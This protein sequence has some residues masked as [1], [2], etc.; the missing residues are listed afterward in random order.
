MKKTV[1][2][3]LMVLCMVCLS[4]LFAAV[5]VAAATDYGL[6]I[7]GKAVT[8][9]YK[10][11]ASEGW[12]F[13]PAANTLTLTDG[14]KFTA[15]FEKMTQAKDMKIAT[16]SRYDPSIGSAAFA[17]YMAA[18]EVKTLTNLTVKVTGDVT[19]GR[20][21]WSDWSNVG[22]TSERSPIRSLGFYS[23]SGGIT[24][25]GDGKLTVY[26]SD[27]AFY[28]NGDFK[29]DGKVRLDLETYRT[30]A[31]YAQGKIIIDNGS[32]V[33][34]KTNY[35]CGIYKSYYSI[36]Y[37]DGSKGEKDSEGTIQYDSMAAVISTKGT[38]PNGISVLNGSTL[39][40]DAHLGD[41]EE[42]KIKL[43]QNREQMPDAS[44]MSD[45]TR[46][47]YAIWA[48]RA[49]INIEGKSKLK[50]DIDA[51]GDLYRRLHPAVIGWKCLY[52]TI[53]VNASNVTVKNSDLVIEAD[54]RD[55][56]FE[57]NGI[58]YTGKELGDY[59]E[60][61]YDQSFYYPETS[62]KDN[63]I[64]AS[65]FY[66]RGASSVQLSMDGTYGESNLCRLLDYKSDR[67]EFSSTY[68]GKSY[69]YCEYPRGDYNGGVYLYL[70]SYEKG[71]T[72]YLRKNGDKYEY[73]E[74]F[75]FRSGIKYIN[76]N[77]LDIAAL[78]WSNKTIYIRSGN[79]TIK[80]PVN[81]NAKIIHDN[82]ESTVTIKLEGGKTYNGI[83][84]VTIA[85]KLI[86]EGDGIIKELHTHGTSTLMWDGHPGLYE[87]AVPHIFVNSGTIAGGSSN[88]VRINV[89]GG[90][91]AYN[92]D[93]QADYYGPN[94]SRTLKRITIDLGEF[95]DIFTSD[96]LRISS[97][98]SH[99]TTGLYPVDG[100][101]YFWELEDK[102]WNVGDHPSQLEFNHLEITEDYTYY[103]YPKKVTDSQG[104]VINRQY[105]LYRLPERL[106]IY[107][108]NKTEYFESGTN[109]YASGV[110]FGSF[111]YSLLV[112]RPKYSDPLYTAETTT[113]E[114]CR[115]NIP[116]NGD[117]VEWTCK[118]KDGNKITLGR[119]Y[120]SLSLTTG[121]LHYR[122]YDYKCTLY[123]IDGKVK[124]SYDFD[125]YILLFYNTGDQYAAKGQ[126]VTFEAQYY[127][128]GMWLEDLGFQWAWQ[129]RTGS[130]ATWNIVYDTDAFFDYTAFDESFENNSHCYQFR[131][132]AYLSRINEELVLIGSPI[133]LLN[134]STHV[135]SAPET[136]NIQSN[137]PAETIQIT[138][139]AERA[140]II[141]WWYQKEGWSDE[142]QISGANSLTLSLPRS[143]YTDENG[144]WDPSKVD[145]TYYCYI[146]NMRF[147][148][149]T[150]VEIDVKVVDH[151][152]FT[153][154]PKDKVAA[155]G[156]IAEFNVGISKDPPFCGELW[157]EYSF[158]DGATWEKVTQ[159]TSNESFIVQPSVYFIPIETDRGIVFHSHYDAC[160]LTVNAAGLNAEKILVRCGMKDSVVTY[161]TKTATLT[162]VDMPVI[163]TQPQSQVVSVTQGTA[164]MEYAF[165]AP[166]P[167]EYTVT[168]QWQG[169]NDE[170]ELYEHWE[171][172]NSNDTYTCSD[173]RIEFNLSKHLF[174]RKYRCKI[175]FTDA[176]GVTIDVYTAEATLE[177]VTMPVIRSITWSSSYITEG[178]HLA[179]Y[180]ARDP[181]AYQSTRYT[182]YKWQICK[183]G[184]N[185]VEPDDSFTMSTIGNDKFCIEFDTTKEMDGW[186]VRFL[187]IN[188]YGGITNTAISGA[189][190]LNVLSDECA[191]EYELRQ[192]VVY[193]RRKGYDT[194][195]LTGDITLTS[196]LVLENTYLTDITID[197]NGHIL[198]SDGGKFTMLEVQ[199]GVKLTIIDSNPT[200][201]NGPDIPFTGGSIR[202]AVGEIGGAVKLK[203]GATFNFNAGTIYNCT[204]TRGAAVYMELGDKDTK[205]NMNGG[206]IYGCS[207]TDGA[208]VNIAP[209]MNSFVMNSGSISGCTADL[210][211]AAVCMESSDSNS[212]VM[213]GGEISNC[214]ANYGGAAVYIYPGKHKFVMNDGK[215]VGCNQA[216]AGAAS[217]DLLGGTIENCPSVIYVKDDY[218]K[219]TVRLNGVAIRNCVYEKTGEVDCFAPIYVKGLFIMEDGEISSCGN[220]SGN[221]GVIYLADGYCGI[222]GGT[223][224]DCYSA[225][226]NGGAIYAEAGQVRLIG[227]I[228]NCHAQNGDGGAIYAKSGRVYLLSGSMIEDCTAAGKGSAIYSYAPIWAD[229]GVISGTVVA[230]GG[231]EKLQIDD[232]KTT[233]FGDVTCDGEDA[234]GDIKTGMY[235]GKVTGISE[236]EDVVAVYF[237]SDGE[238]YATFVIKKGEAVK[239]PIT[240]V[241]TRTFIGWYNGDFMYDFDTPVNEDLILTA[242]WAISTDP[243]SQLEKD[244]DELKKAL[245]KAIADGDKSLDDKIKALNDALNAAKVALQAE[246][247][248]N[249]TALEGQIS[250]AQTTLQAAIDQ[251][252]KNLDDAKA[253][254]D[255]AIADGDKAL[256]DT[257]QAL[258]DALDAAKAALQAED[259]ANK[260]ALEG[261]ISAA[262]STLQ[263][264]IDQVQKNLDNA[265]AELDKAIADGDK[266]LDDKIKA[267]ND[268]LNAAKTSL[269]A[270][271]ESTKAAL[272]SQIAE[273]K[274]SI[275]IV[276]EQ[277]RKDL[278]DAKAELDKAIADGDK[279]L[280]DKIKALNDA[281]NAA[282]TALEAADEA[283]KTEL[284][285]Q[286]SV[287]QTTL[288]AAID[289]LNNRLATAEDELTATKKALITAII[290]ICSVFAVADIAILTVVLVRTRKNK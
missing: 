245:E 215:I 50:V 149:T 100:K 40:V 101:I 168:Y 32:T 10:S 62:L 262:Q 3:L 205:F 275:Q 164:Y 12:S 267:L 148:N 58:T 216:I 224:K 117:Y 272:E 190:T 247:I 139:N 271:N 24:V 6:E 25:T 276:I 74:Y 108:V 138:V 111:Y 64:R 26:S 203:S 87:L 120:D 33:N 22:M 65:M 204:A 286:I 193:A 221:G 201:D 9:D 265:K 285:G 283:N 210:C 227:T 68:E 207:A 255:K 78:G 11:N 161:Y 231:I 173:Q 147:G 130:K 177:V 197:L 141:T 15:A 116:Q 93:M 160:K 145:G 28:T 92:E 281:L 239:V 48:D 287:A 54:N 170:Y 217:V 163:G 1:R 212:F 131:R 106:E 14:N 46:A 237:Y 105:K 250:A 289:A 200:K 240:P 166:L 4:A 263:A 222:G 125:V 146:N 158:D 142:V 184:V 98:F 256:D 72:Y 83:Y 18:V 172:V 214:T 136:F 260:T 192:A 49:D 290:V 77:V 258:H 179:I 76:S 284:E 128:D 84:H 208:A 85:G 66:M 269:E 5:D 69:Y 155:T 246:D 257:V 45:G 156:G 112:D 229:G 144:N 75:D 268:A 244:L 95:A 21:N 198:Q 13:D 63:S 171:D 243:G 209:G 235:Y 104:N 42:T 266:A 90:N 140:H 86:V 122:N 151:V 274:A 182:G 167:E 236:D 80:L 99:N 270:A 233:F 37:Y 71:S 223:V 230:K 124:K 273:A 61:F 188:E 191:N 254:L 89:L 79:Y 175:S 185:W 219:A 181:S 282:K 264:A 159:G 225:N 110:V 53:V 279:A 234:T 186:K 103:V 119:S 194:L 199:D 259:T 206:A 94:G 2:I 174:S 129:W 213:N 31:I 253:D 153:S 137:D 162:F 60:F 252:Q 218:L 135:L 238:V 180:A 183:D 242:K 118:D 55:V 102:Y 57:K 195:K 23:K 114:L 34:A 169:Y 67:F 150:K 38:H 17:F 81:N 107:P 133:M 19:V 228:Q 70:K 36:L 127:K 27:S 280:D 8:S 278:N 154:D 261:Q 277:I 109:D 115:Y 97:E 43:T 165:E 121:D 241:D 178:D 113:T 20:S 220:K 226:G 56:S 73:S 251:V 96:M 288:Q 91:V 211:G 88:G 157:W 7:F 249:K 29:T 189:L 152:S 187:L 52:R 196:T 47:Y 202:G 126:T 134:M 59:A 35:L 16:F 41:V 123:A 39:N 232:T 51:A 176:A 132:V 82:W 248:A 143:E 44:N 30:A